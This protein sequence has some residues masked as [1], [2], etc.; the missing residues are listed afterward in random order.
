MMGFAISK[1]II[2]KSSFFPTKLPTP[3]AFALAGICPMHKVNP[4]STWVFPE[5][6]APVINEIAS[7]ARSTTV[8][9]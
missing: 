3:F 4:S 2:E 5:P 7:L 1:V 6:F 8:N 9:S